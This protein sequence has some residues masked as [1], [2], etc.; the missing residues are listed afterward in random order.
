[1][2][3]R[4]AV[5]NW[6]RPFLFVAE[7]HPLSVPSHEVAYTA[8]FFDGEGC[9]NI[10][11]YLKRGRPYHIL[12]IIFTNTNFQVLEWLHQRWGGNLIRQVVRGN[13]RHRPCGYLRLSPGPARPLLIAM[14]PYLIIKKSEAEIALQFIEAKSDNRTGRKG[15]PAAL[16]RRADLATSL[17]RPRSRFTDFN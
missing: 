2:E 8:G 7:G 17:P 1:M 10:A 9:V 4:T 16:A 14:L 13:P 11:R 3:A 12:A 5:D 15:D 6:L